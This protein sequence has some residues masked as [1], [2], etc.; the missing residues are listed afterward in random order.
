MR[1]M[2]ILAVAV[3]FFATLLAAPLAS[4]ARIRGVDGRWYEVN[5]QAL[6]HHNDRRGTYSYGSDY[7][8]EAA[9]N[10]GKQTSSIYRQ[11]KHSHRHFHAYRNWYDYCRNNWRRDPNC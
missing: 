10:S 8:A 2:K 3:A 9:A 7:S 6:R 1:S 11:S 4:A 5:E